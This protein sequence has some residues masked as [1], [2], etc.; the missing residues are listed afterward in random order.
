MSKKNVVNDD[1]DVIK[2]II[3]GEQ[4]QIPKPN[5]PY[6]SVQKSQDRKTHCQAR[7]NV[8][9]LHTVFFDC[10]VVVHYEFLS[11]GCALN[12]IYCLDIKSVQSLKGLVCIFDESLTQLIYHLRLWGQILL[13]ILLLC[14]YIK[15]FTAAKCFQTEKVLHSVNSKILRNFTK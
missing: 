8:K 13:E 6:G 2:K 10:N 9:V 5:H 1:W 3:I 4:S 14:Q 11:Q 15:L 12:K 7:S